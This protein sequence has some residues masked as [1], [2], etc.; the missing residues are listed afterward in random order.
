MAKILSDN[1]AYAKVVKLMG[2]NP[3]CTLLAPSHRVVG[4]RTSAAATDFASI[5]PED[6]EATI[7]A[8]AEISMGTEISDSDLTHI[9][10]LC[11]QVISISEY[12]AQLS[13]YLR[14]RMIAIAPNLTAIVGELVGAR[15]ISHA[16]SLL[17]LAKHPASTVQ[18]LGAEKALFRALKTKH[19]TPKYGLIYHA[20]LVGQAPPKLKGKVR[21]V[22]Y[23]SYLASAKSSR[24]FLQM[25][26]MVATKTAL[27]VRVDALTVTDEKDEKAEPSAP[28]IGLEN[29][30]KLEARLR[31]L[32]AEGDASGVRR[33]HSGPNQQKRVKPEPAV[34]TYNTAADAVGLVSTQREPMETAVKAALDVKEEKRRVKEERRAKRREEKAKVE[35]PDEDEADAMEVDADEKKRKRRKSDAVPAL[36][37]GAVPMVRGS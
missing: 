19:D 14:N 12:R 36:A 29:R 35:E 28:T 26:R 25:A 31:V 27:S 15:L 9:H 24:F 30:A 10:A 1:L 8:A 23:L 11:D 37:D 2:N 18:I 3:L 16:G 4:F 32:E 7:K 21:D 22:I 34:P 33:F 20:S 13:E 17:N 5:L 6:L